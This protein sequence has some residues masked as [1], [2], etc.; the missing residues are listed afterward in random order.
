VT[1]QS[2]ITGGAWIEVSDLDVEYG[3]EMVQAQEL[4][5]LLPSRG[6]RQLS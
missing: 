3:H 6:R 2:L 5:A 1:L 4:A